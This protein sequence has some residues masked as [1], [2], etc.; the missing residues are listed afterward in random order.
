MEELDVQT[1]QPLNQ[2]STPQGVVNTPTQMPMN[3]AMSTPPVQSTTKVAQDQDTL[4]ASQEALLAPMPGNILKILV[5][6]GQ[7]VEENQPILILEAM[8]M[9]NEIVADKSGIVQAIYVTQGAMV[10]PGDPL[11]LIN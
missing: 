4:P 1:N 5:E 8:K 7:K 6:V 11:V 10:N 3:Q 2:P 9:E